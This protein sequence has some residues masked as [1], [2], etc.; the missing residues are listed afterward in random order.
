LGWN[1][2]KIKK[3]P[4]IDALVFLKNQFSGIGRAKNIF[5]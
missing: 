4:V 1:G 2:L 3:A 5:I